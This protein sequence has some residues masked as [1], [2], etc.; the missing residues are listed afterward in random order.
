MGLDMY[1]S[2]RETNPTEEVAY[3][4]KANMVHK[5]FVDNVQNGEDNC[6]PYEVD[7]DDLKEL[8]E[9]CKKLNESRD[10]EQ[11]ESLLPTQEGFFFG[12]YEYDKYYWEDIEETIKMLEEVIKEHEESNIEYVYTYC[13]SW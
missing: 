3:W 1:L 8:L 9:I 12:S 6:K 2:R 13:S 11:A 10:L 5:W 7:I 4:R